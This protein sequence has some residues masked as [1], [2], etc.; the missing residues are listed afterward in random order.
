ME[1]N[2][3]GE[4]IFLKLGKSSALNTV[5]VDDNCCLVVECGIVI[6]LTT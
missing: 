3:I 5:D 4:L 2:E 6:K 1:L